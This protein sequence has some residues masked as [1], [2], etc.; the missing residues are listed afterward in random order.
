M[1]FGHIVNSNATVIILL[2]WSAIDIIF[3]DNASL[4]LTNDDRFFNR[5]FFADNRITFFGGKYK[6]EKIIMLVLSVRPAW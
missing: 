3:P 2:W 4:I 5:S 1:L 6:W